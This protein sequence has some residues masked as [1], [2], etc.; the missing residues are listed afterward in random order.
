MDCYDI[1]AQLKLTAQ[2]ME[3]HDEN[4]F[5]IKSLTNASFNF[6]KLSLAETEMTEEKL[7]LMPGIGKGTAKTIVEI[8]HKGSSADLDRLLELTPEGVREM[9]DV[10]GIGPK[11]VKQLW[12]ELGIESP[13]ELLYACHENRLVELK[14]FGVKTQQ[15][16]KESI[17]FG[18]ASAGKLHYATVEAFAHEVIETIKKECHPSHIS[19]TGDILRRCEILERIDVLLVSAKKC[20]LVFEG[21]IPVHLI[22]TDAGSFYYELVKT[23]SAKEHLEKIKLDSLANKSFASSGEVYKSLQMPYFMPEW[24]DGLFEENI[25]SAYPKELIEFSHLKGALHNH[26]KY[27]DG[28]NTV[29]DMAKQCIKM[30]YEYFGIADHSKSATYANGLSTER[31]KQQHEEID[32]LNKKLA[33][34]KILKGIECDILYDGSL[35]YDEEVLKTFD[36][37]VTSIHQHFKMD[38]EKATARLIKAIENPYTTILGHPT[39]RLLLARKGYPVNHKKIIDACAGNGVVVE[40]NAHPYRLDIDWRWIPYCME[41]NVM[42]SI[43]PDAHELAGIADMHY[44]VLAARKGLLEKSSC[45]NAMGLN[46]MEA[47]LKKK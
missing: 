33:P 21:I 36:Y 39:G 11:K 5:K 17:E 13:G 41:K 40:L 31:V 38:E 14:G 15:S 29:E 28:S 45:F 12:R 43:N 4:P 7:S 19:L 6:S 34:F 10:K 24:R 8:A 37:V 35:D 25:I 9:L 42:I 2:L 16:V 23:S 1:A 32:A 18:M 3:L 20:E 26:S 22:Y 47:F 46:E 27:S 44:G 30:G